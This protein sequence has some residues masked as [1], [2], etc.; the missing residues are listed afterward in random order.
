VYA[1]EGGN[2]GYRT[3][4]GGSRYNGKDLAKRVNDKTPNVPDGLEFTYRDTIQ[5]L[6]YDGASVDINLKF[7]MVATHLCDG[8]VR[9]LA[10]QDVKIAGDL[11]DGRLVPPK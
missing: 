1:T 8:E 10:T 9:V 4:N 5:T 6:Y 2:H 11:V 3:Y 7:R